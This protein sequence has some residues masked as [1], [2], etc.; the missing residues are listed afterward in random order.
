MRVSLISPGRHHDGSPR[1]EL[2]FKCQ[3]HKKSIFTNYLSIKE[4]NLQYGNFYLDYEE[5][6]DLGIVPTRDPHTTSFVHWLVRIGTIFYDF[7][8]DIDVGDS[9][10]LVTLWW[11]LISDVGGCYAESLCWR[12]F[13]LCNICW[14][15][16]QCIKS[17][18]NIS[19]LSPTHLVSN[20][21]HQHRCNILIFRLTCA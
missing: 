19:N 21:R 10:M 20:I 15:F 7:Y 3:K 1:T 18:T 13:S 14:W 5:C 8:G 11:W 16:F 12:R 9:V 6:R 4:K 2:N 17:V